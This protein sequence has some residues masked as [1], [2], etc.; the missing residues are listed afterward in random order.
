VANAGEHPSFPKESLSA[1]GGVE[2]GPQHLYGLGEVE[3]EIVRD[4]D[5]PHPAAAEQTLDL[6]VRPY[7]LLQAFLQRIDLDGFLRA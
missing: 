5:V 1:R 2:L 4:V 3:P 6:V 7:S